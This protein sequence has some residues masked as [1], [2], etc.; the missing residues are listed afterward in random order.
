M[1]DID[2]LTNKDIDR[3]VADAAEYLNSKKG[4]KDCKAMLEEMDR[5][6]EKLC[7]ARI[8]TWQMMMEPITI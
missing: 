7:Q 4:R 2:T 6:K 1:A 8:V 3:M 5:V